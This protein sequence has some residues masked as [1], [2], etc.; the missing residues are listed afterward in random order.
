MNNAEIIELAN[1]QLAVDQS[2]DNTDLTERFDAALARAGK[3]LVFVPMCAKLQM[4]DFVIRGLQAQHRP[5]SSH[6]SR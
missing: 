4:I 2:P 5:G 6:S 1:L 3:D